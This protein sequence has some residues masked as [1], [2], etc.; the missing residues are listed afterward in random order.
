M[1]KRLT[2]RQKTIGAFARAFVV[3]GM[4]PRLVSRMMRAHWRNI[5]MPWRMLPMPIAW[6]LIGLVALAMILDTGDDLQTSTI[7]ANTV[8]YALDCE[9]DE[10]IAFDST[11]RAP[12]PLACVHIDTLASPPAA[13]VA[14]VEPHYHEV[15]TPTPTPTPTASPTAS[16]TPTPTPALSSSP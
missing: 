14:T 7:G 8:P 16:P 10:V 11:A 12:Y 3:A 6:A 1:T 4:R 15:P 13:V 5:L 2:R 9:E